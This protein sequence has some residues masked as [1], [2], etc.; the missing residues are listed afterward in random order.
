[1]TTSILNFDEKEIV[2]DIF[3]YFSNYIEKNKDKATCYIEK[4]SNENNENIVS[5]RFAKNTY[6]E[7]SS[8]SELK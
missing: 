8:F 7:E 6:Y 5:F 4:L 2:S 1:M 3:N